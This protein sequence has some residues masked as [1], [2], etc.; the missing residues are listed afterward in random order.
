MSGIGRRD[1]LKVSL[2]AGAGLAGCRSTPSAQEATRAK[3]P[4]VIWLWMG[5]GMSQ[6]DTFDPKPGTKFAG[7][8]KAI[9]TS[10]PGVQFCEL[11]PRS[12]SQMKHL[13]LIRS[14]KTGEGSL[15]RGTALMHVGFEGVPG[16]D[17]PSIGTVVAHELGN[18][19]FPLPRF[20]TLDPPLIP[21]SG[22]FGEECRPFRLQNADEPIP[23]LRPSVERQRERDRLALLGE[24]TAEWEKEHGG[25]AAERLQ[26]AARQAENLMNSPLLRAFNYKTEP[27]ALRRKYGDRFGTNCLLA[28]RLVQAGCPFVEIGLGGWDIP[29][30][31][32]SAYRRLLPTLDQAFGTLIEDLAEKDMLRET[33]VVLATPFGRTPDTNAGKGRDRR[34]DGFSIVLAGA[35]LRPGVVYGSTGADGHDC[36]DP[37]TP[38]RLF[39]TLYR[40]LGIDPNKTFGISPDPTRDTYTAPRSEPIQELLGA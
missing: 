9:D 29:S 1:F 5:G 7:E 19:D 23:N 34:A 11:L 40:A 18:K 14:M 27:E 22:V 4:G 16:T 35:G 38:S 28:R 20:L 25:E 2:A 26:A 33:M 8:F 36:I 13:A 30:D 24:Q 10:V 39:T 17:Y 37:V 3:S 32:F 15:E 12:A 6:I 31:H 21:S